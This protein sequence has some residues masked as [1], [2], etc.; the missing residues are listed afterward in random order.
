MPEKKALAKFTT[1]YRNQTNTSQFDFASNCGISTEYLSLIER[2]KAN[3]SLETM[4]KIAA[5]TG[6]TVAEMLTVT[7]TTQE[8]WGYE[9]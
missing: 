7:N 8:K 9:I 1:T 2:Q 6:A 3:P 4:Q 5:Y